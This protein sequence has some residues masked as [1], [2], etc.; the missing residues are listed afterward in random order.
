MLRTAFVVLIALAACKKDAAP[1]SAPPTAG[2]V[3]ADGIRHVAIGVDD[4]GYHPDRIEG[5]PGEKVV[6]EFT[7]TF[8]S[9]C[10]AQVKAPD[11]KMYDLPMNKPVQVAVTVPASG[12]VGF[13]CGMDMFHGVIAAKK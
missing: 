7:R 5:A 6:L 12:D 9:T 1:T 8:D 4:K 13:A 10:I 2:T 11:G 3:A